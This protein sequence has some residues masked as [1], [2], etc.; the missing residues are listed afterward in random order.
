MKTKRVF[1]R[2]MLRDTGA[3]MLLTDNP[4][5]NL[6]CAELNLSKQEG[7]YEDQEWCIFKPDIQLNNSRITPSVN[8][9][10][11]KADCTRDSCANLEPR[12]KVSYA[13]NEYF[14]GQDQ[15][16][17]ACDFQGIGI[18]IKADPSTKTCTFPSTF[19]RH[20]LGHSR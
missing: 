5:T 1:F 19:C 17:V 4:N 12:L 11:S 6:F 10:C 13:L 2:V 18:V 7:F 20:I 15:D 14:Q 3:S 16:E 8:Y 9:A